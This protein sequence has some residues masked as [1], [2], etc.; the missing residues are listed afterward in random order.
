M[1]NEIK[2]ELNLRPFVIVIGKYDQILGPRALYSSFTIND[3]AFIRNL[4]RD[5]L[6]TKNKFVTLDYNEFYGQVCKVEV[7]DPTARGKKQ[8]YAIIL[9]RHVDLPIIPNLHFKRIEM[10]F[11]K[12]DRGLI[13]NDDFNAFDAF[14]NE[15]KDIY[16]KKDE[17]LPLESVTMQ[18]RSG[19]N[20][21]QGFCQIL[22]ED[23][24]GT[25]LDRADINAYLE[26]MLDSCQDMMEA[27]EEYFPNNDR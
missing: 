18:V 10:I 25:R 19:I 6:N 27:L 8:L 15:V 21:I 16:M 1:Y 11:H 23:K 20:T 2:E 13:L 12:L 26:M 9:I 14:F 5:S 17:V 22:M 4:L 24:Q 3:E 7:D